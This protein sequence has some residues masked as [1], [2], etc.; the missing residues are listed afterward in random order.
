MGVDPDRYGKHLASSEVRRLLG[1]GE[2][3]ILFV[4]RFSASKGIV[5]LVRAMPA[6]A[7]RMPQA[8]LAVVGFG[9]DEG[10]IR[11]AV[12]ELDLGERVSLVGR[13]AREDIP[14]H[15]ASADLV[16]LPSVKVE[17]LGVVLL[18]A[19]ASGTPVV[20]SDVGGIPDII[21]NGVTGL[22][23]RSQDPANIA[24]TCLRMLLD[25]EL[26]RR[27]AE[28]GRRLVVERFSWSRIGAALEMILDSCVSGAPSAG[29][30][31]DRRAEP[32]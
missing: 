15:L 10:R 8:K 26:R 14:V 11:A 22:L 12:A 27:T 31:D 32:S 18:E 29:S 25:A 4:G 21:E 2:P 3:Q 6:I 13:V 19:L 28:S 16:V 23:C 9:P 24:D 20:G 5:D 7:S 1:G 30:R 17:G